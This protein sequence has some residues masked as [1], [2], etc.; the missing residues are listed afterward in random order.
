MRDVARGVAFCVQQ[1]WRAGPVSLAVGWMIQLL[2]SLVPAALVL[3]TANL[4]ERLDGVV[5]LR[6]VLGQLL[7]VVAILGLVGP[8]R[9][10]AN[11]LRDQSE[12][13]GAAAMSGAVAQ[14]AARTPPS[15]LAKPEVTAQ[16]ERHS[17][18][19]WRGVNILPGN[20][21]F[22]IQD[23]VSTGAVVLAI[24]TLS[25]LAGVLTALALLPASIAG[26]LLARHVSTFLARIG[27]LFAREQYFKNLLV[28]QRSAVELA[29]LGGGE[30]VA[31][32]SV[33]HWRTFVA[34]RLALS[35]RQLRL[36]W[37]VGVISTVGVLGALI[38]LLSDTGYSAVA[39]AGISGIISGAGTIAG[40]GSNIG[41]LLSYGP[42][43]A[44]LRDFI[45]DAPPPRSSVERVRA[46][47][48][49]SA[50]DLSHT[51]PDRDAPAL[52]DVSFEAKRG[53]MIALV[54]ANGAGKTTAVRALLGLIEPDNGRVEAD[55]VRP[56]DVGD[57]AWL[58][59]FGVLVQ[60]YERYELTVRQNLL[61]GND[62]EISDEQL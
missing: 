3:V 8:V 42:V 54:G 30:W 2:L 52:V 1:A 28:R 49:L 14:R 24:A 50:S 15:E 38:A 11:L 58:D 51:Y 37:G 35:R 46:V 16:L 36:D 19:V 53:E 61:L 12:D 29:T 62:D 45:E 7:M 17:E 60:E 26:Q 13:A 57:R 25:P 31:Q 10:V 41:A 6:D 34:A 5:T 20:L 21:V 47:E 39:V 48:R 56:A 59:R 55:G 4:I 23:V 9:G 43:A 33:E 44:E 27:K 22:A 32:R 18:A 40:A